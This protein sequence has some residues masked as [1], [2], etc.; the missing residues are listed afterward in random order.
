MPALYISWNNRA[1]HRNFARGIGKKYAESNIVI[2]I[3]KSPIMNLTLLPI[4]GIEKIAQEA[5]NL[6]DVCQ[7]SSIK[8]EKE[9]SFHKICQFSSSTMLLPFHFFHLDLFLPEKYPSYVHL[10]WLSE[11]YSQY[12]FCLKMSLFLP[13]LLNNSLSLYRVVDEY[14][15]LQHFNLA[16]KL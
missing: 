12:F 2:N 13:L 6:V 16:D 11:G 5:K 15:F 4:G 9:A 7:Q 1:G 8:H 14:F 3:C 10:V